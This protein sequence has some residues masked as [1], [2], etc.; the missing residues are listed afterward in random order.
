VIRHTVFVIG[1]GV[2]QEV[3]VVFAEEIIFER[4]RLLS[5]VLKECGQS[6]DEEE[7]EDKAANEELCV[8]QVVVHCVLLCIGFS[9]R[10]KGWLG[11]HDTEMKSE[12]RGSRN[13]VKIAQAGI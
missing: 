11:Q 4:R 10:Q 13:L 12:A 6:K 7:C 1:P 2:L 9:L 3:A 8:C 5:Q